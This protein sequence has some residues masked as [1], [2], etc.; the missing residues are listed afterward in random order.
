M[1]SRTLI[2]CLSDAFTSALLTFEKNDECGS[3]HFL[4]NENKK[5]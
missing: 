5:F 1:H 2:P 4:K 3:I